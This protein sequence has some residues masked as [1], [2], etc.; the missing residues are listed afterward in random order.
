[1]SDGGKN[2]DSKTI[3]ASSISPVSPDHNQPEENSEP[4]SG[5]KE[6]QA[7][8]AETSFPNTCA[9]PPNNQPEENIE[10]TSSDIQTPIAKTPLPNTCA[11]SPNNQPEENIELTSGDK[12][13]QAPIQGP[14]GSKSEEQDTN[15]EMK[16]GINVIIKKANITLE[17][18]DVIVNAANGRLMH[19]GGVARAIAVKAGPEIDIEGEKKLQERGHTLGVSEVLHTKGYKLDAKFVIHAVGPIQGRNDQ[20][21]SKLKKTFFNCLSYADEKLKAKSI[22]I[23]L[24]SSG[25]FG[26]QKMECAKALI[27]SINS[28][29][30]DDKFEHVKEIRLVNI[31]SQ[32]TDAITQLS[33]KLKL[34]HKD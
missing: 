3:D 8:I 16:R 31:D 2:I 27:D 13:I 11:I 10:L 33:S 34:I 9:I 24:I 21:Q 30:D 26:G 6:I 20:F 7:P 25:I 22:A 19:G 4:A 5:D 18:V 32:A 12:E 15:L 28:F 14:T 23:P 1:M 17:T 29:V